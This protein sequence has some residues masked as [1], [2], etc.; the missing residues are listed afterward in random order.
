[1]SEN[2]HCGFVAIVGRPNVGKSTLLNRLIGQK[3]SITSRKPQTTRQQV[4]GIKTA[5]DAQIIY[6][7]TPGLHRGRGKALNRFMNREATRAFLDV[8]VIVFLI[9]ALRWTEDDQFVFR[10]IEGSPRPIILAV[11]KVD[12]VP[13]KSQLLPFLK[14]MGE[15]SNF[16]EIVPL[17]GLTGGNT[18]ALESQLIAR[19]PAAPPMF[20]EDQVSDR[21]ERF[22]A[23]ELIREKLLRKLSQEVPHQLSVII[24]EFKEQKDVLHIYATIWVERPG[25]KQIVI[26]K[27]GAV[28]KAVGEEARRDMERMFGEKVFL[29]TWVKV[30]EGWSDDERALKELGLGD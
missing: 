5:D 22:F 9:E 28:L 14:Q 2:F 23:A 19:L 8:D 16:A 26:G 4:I 10:Q 18:D 25:Q 29:K 27:D 24:E 1:M 21:S 17:S 20:P 30:K 12:R 3:I 7:D 13:D 11:N 15:L 6:I